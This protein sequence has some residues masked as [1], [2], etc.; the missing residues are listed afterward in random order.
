MSTE[1]PATYT[2]A[3]LLYHYLGER[4]AGPG[5]DTPLQELLS[6]FVQYRRELRDL[7]TK[8]KEAEASSA[9][10]ES[11]ELDVETLVSEVTRELAAD[12]ITD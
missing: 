6:G 9:R 10:G 5:C 2:D 1:L 7:R 4:M 11:E 3:E 12:G 8:L